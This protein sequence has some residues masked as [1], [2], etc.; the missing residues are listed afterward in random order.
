MLL[1]L[2]LAAAVFHDDLQVRQDIP[3][4]ANHRLPFPRPDDSGHAPRSCVVEAVAAEPVIRASR[5]PVSRSRFEHA[6]E[7][8]ALVI[9][10]GGEEERG[11]RPVV[12]AALA[13]D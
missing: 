6:E 8:V 1:S 9:R 13:E 4:Q 7:A 10:A 5:P 12:G 11:G 3:L 2:E